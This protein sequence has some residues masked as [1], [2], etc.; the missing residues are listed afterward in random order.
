M[1][2]ERIKELFFVSF[3]FL[4]NLIYHDGRNTNDKFLFCNTD[5]K[6]LTVDRIGH[7][8]TEFTSQNGIYHVTFTSLRKAIESSAELLS[9]QLGMVKRN[10]ISF[11]SLHQTLTGIKVFVRRKKKF[12]CLMWWM[13]KK[14]IGLYNNSGQFFSIENWH[15]LE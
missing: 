14:K 5:G 8:L 13:L 2:V 10:A 12:V 9:G 7:I 6:A 15:H 11:H 3:F 4:R 1:S